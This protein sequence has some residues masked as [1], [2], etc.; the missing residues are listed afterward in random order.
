[1]KIMATNIDKFFE[2]CKENFSISDGDQN[3][4]SNDASSNTMEKRTTLKI[5][6]YI[7]FD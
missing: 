2:M 5:E 3:I 7:P 1:M 6:G 4:K